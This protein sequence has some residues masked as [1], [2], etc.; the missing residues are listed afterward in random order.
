M[1]I[2]GAC[3]HRRAAAH[4]TQCGGS[5][6]S[7]MRPAHLL[8]RSLSPT[9]HTRRKSGVRASSSA[10]PFAQPS[11][12]PLATPALPELGLTSG[13]PARHGQESATQP[14]HH[15][16]V[17]R[18]LMKIPLTPSRMKQIK[19]KQKQTKKNRRTP[20]KG[21]GSRQM[22]SRLFICKQ[23]AFR[24]KCFH[25]LS[26][27]YRIILKIDTSYITTYNFGIENKYP[28]PF[29][30]PLLPFAPHKVHS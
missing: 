20:E 15:Q 16:G 24:S 19:V 5:F 3:E 27:R 2:Q 11:P 28:A 12:A 9:A 17:T 6:C 21:C 22:P 25:I 18:R 10:A 26:K 23:A 1:C 4:P 14:L 13:P 8:S 30:C 7:H 29:P